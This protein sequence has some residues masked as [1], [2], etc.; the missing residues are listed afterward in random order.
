MQKSHTDTV[1]E[2][3]VC[4]KHQNGKN[5]VFLTSKVV[6]LLV[7]DG[8]DEQSRNCWEFRNNVYKVHTEWCQKQKPLSE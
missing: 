5:V 8:L 2:F 1:Q 3:H 6:W 4:I 7:P